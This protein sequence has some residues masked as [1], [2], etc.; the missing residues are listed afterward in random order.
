MRLALGLT[1]VVCFL[2]AGCGDQGAGTGTTTSTGGSGT[3]TGPSAT[4]PGTGANPGDPTATTSTTTASPK[5][6]AIESGVAALS[7]EN[8]KIQFV[9]THSPP[10]APDPRTG[11]FAKFTGKA[12]VD[13]DGKALKTVSVEIDT[14]SIWTQIDKLTN[15]L[16]SQDFFDARENPT[17]KF[18]STKIEPG[19][20]GKCTITGNLTLLKTTKEISFPAT[21][22]VGDDGLTLTAEFDID[23][24][25]FG[26]GKDQAGVENIVKMTVVVGEKTQPLTGGSQ[27]GGA[28]GRSPGRTNRT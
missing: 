1:A 12:E 18:E 26:I 11:G 6:V 14:N 7:P 4:S 23:R 17:A 3:A 28:A 5:P 22:A 24:M 9:G 27:P 10:K 20:A 25:E 15:H 19:D 2:L 8:T 13:A 21:V 16:K